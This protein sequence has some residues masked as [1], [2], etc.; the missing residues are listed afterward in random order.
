[1]TTRLDEI[2]PRFRFLSVSLT[3][4]RP[5]RLR[6][7]AA[8]VAGILLL[9]TSWGC[10]DPPGGG[11]LSG[12]SGAQGA[13]ADALSGD[14]HPFGADDDTT[15]S[16]M[17]WN[18]E[19]FYDNETGDNYSDLAKQKSAP[20]RRAWNWHRD[21][22]AD[23]IAEV[24]PTV[25]AVQEAEN[26]RVLWYLARALRR[27]H[28][29][30]YREFDVE[31]RDHA[32]EQDVGFLVREPAE[33]LSISRH[34][35]PRRLR[36]SDRFAAVSKHALLEIE[37]PSAGQTG[38]AP[39]VET[40]PLAASDRST[41]DR[42][43]TGA[44]RRIHLMN[45]HLRAGGD[46][47]EER[48]RQARAVRHWIRP[49]VLRGEHVI[50]LGDL[51]T[52]ETGDEPGPGSELFVLLGRE[53]SEPDDDL[54]DLHREIPA[55]RRQT[56]LLPGRQFD[57]ILVTPSLLGDGG[58]VG[59]GGDEPSW[60]LRSVT[61]RPDLAIRGR[62]DTPGEHWDRYWQMPDDERDLS[63]HYPVI[64]TFSLR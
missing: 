2:E 50:V 55:G 8:R 30:R 35:L 17:T 64:A 57:R 52:S 26:R 4:P 36:D 58:D 16:V 20:N 28:G 53:T 34:S 48:A 46:S 21:G 47:A 6:L 59:D 44:T 22:I 40:D 61:V 13:S 15:F 37:W 9:I 11:D 24:R 42:P 60:R 5:K 27:N 63:D 14:P 1:M 23:A 29:L 56:H 25:V 19:W 33:A 18:L 12:G 39:S 49:L 43:G 10:S 45:L 7:T 62:P 38:D 41:I 31:G 54:V 51:N 3:S 32:T